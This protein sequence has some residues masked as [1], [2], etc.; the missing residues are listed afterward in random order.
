MVKIKKLLFTLLSGISGLLLT[1]AG[2]NLIT[3]TNTLILYVGL[4]LLVV[5][6]LFAILPEGRKTAPIMEQPKEV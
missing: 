6:V 3:L 2:L 4:V 5:A 1:L